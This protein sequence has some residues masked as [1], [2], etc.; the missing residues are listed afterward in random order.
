MTPLSLKLPIRLIPPKSENGYGMY[1]VIFCLFA[2]MAA[3]GGF[4]KDSQ[5]GGF[6]FSSP[7]VR[8]TVVLVYIFALAALARRR[9][10]I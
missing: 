1:G 9:G 4:F 10:Q 3:L 5:I 2:F 8:I 6:G 7:G